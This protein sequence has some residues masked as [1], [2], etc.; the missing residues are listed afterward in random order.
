MVLDEPTLGLDAISRQELFSELLAAVREG[1]RSIFISSHGLSDL[2]RFA[3]HIGMIKRGR[4]LFEGATSEVI[5]R[6]RMVDF[7]A[8][9]PVDFAAHPGF[10]VQKNEG[11]RWRV[12]LDLRQASLDWIKGR[13]ATQIAD[14]PVTLEELFV[15][16]G[17]D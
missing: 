15:A 14:A 7:I 3:D 13:G 2:E 1:D 16:L 8:Q 6:Y 12:L 5:E 9:E 10:V 4:L 11:T 17:R